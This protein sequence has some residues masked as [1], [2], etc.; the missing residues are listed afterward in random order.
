M[1][2][3]TRI[4]LVI[5]LGHQLCVHSVSFPKWTI[6]SSVRQ[7]IL[8]PWQYLILLGLLILANL[9]GLRHEL[10]LQFAFLSFCPFLSVHRNSSHNQ[11]LLVNYLLPGCGL[12][13]PILDGTFSLIEINFNVTIF[14]LYG[15]YFLLLIYN[16]ILRKEGLKLLFYIVS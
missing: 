15:F 4:S 5:M 9:V 7:F 8:H 14:S 13:F 2:Q 11:F 3:C 6:F 16:L 1:C 12:F 10:E